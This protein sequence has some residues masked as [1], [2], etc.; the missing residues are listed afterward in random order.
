MVL[1]DINQAEDS[2]GVPPDRIRRIR[3]V[4]MFEEMLR[5]QPEM[6]EKSKKF[7]EALRRSGSY[8]LDAFV[9]TRREFLGE[10]KLAIAATLIPL[11][12]DRILFETAKTG[13][14]ETGDW[15]RYL[16]NRLHDNI[17]I[18]RKGRLTIL[19]YNYDRSIE[20][21]LHVTLCNALGLD[22]L[23][24][25]TEMEGLEIVHLHGSLGALPWQNNSGEVY[26][27]EYTSSCDFEAVKKAA[28]QIKIIHENQDDTLE[29][30]LALERLSQ[31]ERIC[32]F[33][34]GFHR[35]NVRR[36]TKNKW[37]HASKRFGF[38]DIRGTS[39]GLTPAER[40]ECEKLFGVLDERS[41]QELHRENLIELCRYDDD[42]YKFLRNNLDIIS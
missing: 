36:L 26:S 39:C 7:A 19:T 42:C 13:P 21:Y 23:K 30:L 2:K 8:S 32:F 20:H 37:H 3:S 41:Q 12:Q 31:A 11:E 38:R 25:H 15:Y 6:L 17:G 14:N 9:E 18:G 16:S 22:E 27:R 40:N 35:T 1:R 28:D 33:G 24:S 5:M 34:F 29:Y 4:T 10:C